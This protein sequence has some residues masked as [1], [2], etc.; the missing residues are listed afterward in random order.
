MKSMNNSEH[1]PMTKEQMAEGLQNL[2]IIL[3]GSE[4]ARRGDLI[5]SLMERFGIFEA[6][7]PSVRLHPRLPYVLGNE[8]FGEHPAMVMPL[9][10]GSGA[11]VGVNTIY[12]APGGFAPVVMPN[13]L[14]LLTEYPG[15]FF[16]LDAEIGPVVA[17]A[18]GLGH[19]LSVRALTPI[20]ASMCV[21]RD[22]E[23]LADFDWP[24]GT[25]ELMVLCDDGSR[26][27]AQTLIERARQAG[28]KAQACTPP[29]SGHSWLDEYLF[30][31]AVPT[32]DIAAA[33]QDN[34]TTH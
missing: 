15:M 5:H 26:D 10:T 2:H 13:Q 27:Q 20:K 6:I 7:P 30:H 4:P 25:Q 29:T 23:D 8:V 28:I 3:N 12:L 19:A 1:D 14:A 32:D 21:V 24:D 11:Y 9:R 31:G 17:V 22:R 18:I 16:Q 34:P 33:K